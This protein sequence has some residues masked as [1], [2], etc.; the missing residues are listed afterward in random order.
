M[1]EAGNSHGVIAMRCAKWQYWNASTT[2]SATKDGAIETLG[3][4]VAAP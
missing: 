1:D 2:I 3:Y 4:I